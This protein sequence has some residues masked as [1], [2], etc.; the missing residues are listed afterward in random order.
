MAGIHDGRLSRHHDPARRRLLHIWPFKPAVI[1]LQL[2]LRPFSQSTQSFDL[3]D[4]TIHYNTSPRLGLPD[5]RSGLSRHAGLGIHLIPT[6][7]SQKYNRS[8][9]CCSNVRAGPPPG[10]G[11]KWEVGKTLESRSFLLLLAL[12]LVD[13]RSCN[14]LHDGQRTSRARAPGHLSFD[15]LSH[16]SIVFSL[17]PGFLDR[18]RLLGRDLSRSTLW[19][20]R[21]LL[22]RRLR[23]R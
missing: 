20:R 16:R 6:M 10:G 8:G 13:L 9:C 5:K 1:H 18:G 19:P 3:S 17:L 11:R 14:L 7:P 15:L 21:L 4:L 2:L 22:R 12:G 23:C